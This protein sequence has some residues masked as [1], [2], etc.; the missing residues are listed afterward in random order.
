MKETL[1][2]AIL[3]L[4]TLLWL[5]MLLHFR[6]LNLFAHAVDRNNHDNIVNSLDGRIGWKDLQSF[7]EFD[8]D[9]FQYFLDEAKEEGLTIGNIK[10]SH[11]HEVFDR[12]QNSSSCKR[13]PSPYYVLFKEAVS[14][15]PISL[16][17]VQMERL[18]AYQ[19]Y[20]IL[21]C[22]AKKNGLSMGRVHWNVISKFFAN[23][24]FKKRHPDAYYKIF[25]AAVKQNPMAI[26]LIRP[27]LLND[28]QCFEL[29]L[30][31]ARRNG[32]SICGINWMSEDLP[33][34]EEFIRLRPRA[35]YEIWSSA[36]DQNWKA[37]DCIP[38][39]HFRA[40]DF[41]RLRV[42]AKKKIRRSKIIDG[43]I[44]KIFYE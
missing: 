1:F 27:D 2:L 28:E 44:K 37:F 13:E 34:S 25:D 29:I 11:M 15:N 9:K 6:G 33:F 32:L 18:T 20:E 41:H 42:L 5:D 35:L 40:H 31:A 22:A 39:W 23:E 4:L 12:L 38:R 30:S 26:S 10:W 14:N 19:Q 8:R 24:D 36:V 21:M 43:W 3:C 17:Y 7:R 16:V